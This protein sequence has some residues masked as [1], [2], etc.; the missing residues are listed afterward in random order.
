MC[1]LLLLLL[2]KAFDTVN[3]DLLWS[4]LSKFGCLPQFLRIPRSFHDGM[5][6][7]VT[8]GGRESD[9][10]EALTSWLVSSKVRVLAPFIS[11]SFILTQGDIHV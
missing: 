5:C 2:L 9:S 4:V 7:K 10:F 8:V 11:S 1:V 6:A 3:R